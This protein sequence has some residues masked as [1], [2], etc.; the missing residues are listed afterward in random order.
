MKI[1]VIV[2]VYNVEKYLAKCLDSIFAQTYKDFFVIAV[3]DGSTDSSLK[4]LEEYKNIHN[5][6][7]IINKTNGGLASS[8]NAALNWITDWDDC[9]ITFIDSDDYV[10][11]DYLE[12]LVNAVKKNNSDIVCSSY[13]E[14]Y[15]NG[16]HDLPYYCVEEDAMFDC[17][18]ALKYLFEGKIKSHSPCKLY[19]GY[20]WKDFRYSEDTSFMEDQRTTF[21]IFLKAKHIYYLRYSGYFYVHRL[22]SLCQS[23]M[24]NKKIIDALSCY[25]FN[26]NFNFDG[27]SENIINYFRK[28]ILNEF[29]SVYLMMLPRFKMDIATSKERKDWTSICQFAKT[30]RAVYKFKPTNS[31]EIIKKA[32]YVLLPF[33]YI[34]LFRRF[35]KEYDY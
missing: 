22:G 18:T 12:I 23:P 21:Q 5:N 17:K 34:K 13:F 25:I 9:F 20:I 14:T 29:A 1:Y 6:M 19:K 33:L 11:T 16:S 10:S 28:M 8:R 24:Y 35:L 31:K 3:N 32:T 15:E 2:P 7:T 4:I 26:Y 27:F 30:T